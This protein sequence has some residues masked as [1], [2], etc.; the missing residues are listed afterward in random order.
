MVWPEFHSSL[1]V[2]PSRAYNTAGDERFTRSATL[3][4]ESRFSPLA[5][6]NTTPLITMGATGEFRSR[7]AQPG[8]SEIAP[9]CS[10]PS[11]ATTAPLV[12]VPLDDPKLPGLA[13]TAAKI[14]RV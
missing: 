14:Q 4:L 8:C 10:V 9:P 12:T 13:W 7:E 1:P 2:A 6:A 5:S 11:H 3:S